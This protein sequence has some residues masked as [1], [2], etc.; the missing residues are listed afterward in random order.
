LYQ[1]WT[2][3]GADYADISGMNEWMAGETE[4][5]RENLTNSRST[6]YRSYMTLPG[7]ESGSPEWEACD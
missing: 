5:F 3:D 7:I 6:H 4:V 1:F 2:I